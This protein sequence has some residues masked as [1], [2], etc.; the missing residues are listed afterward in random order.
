MSSQKA[1]FVPGHG[2]TEAIRSIRFVPK[3]DSMGR[4]ESTPASSTQNAA[5][6]EVWQG[7]RYGEATKELLTKFSTADRMATVYADGEMPLVRPSKSAVAFIHDAPGGFEIEFESEFI[8]PQNRVVRRTVVLDDY[9]TCHES[10]CEIKSAARLKSI[11]SRRNGPLRRTDS[12]ARPLGRF[13]GLTTSISQFFRVPPSETSLAARLDIPVEAG[14]VG[15]NRTTRLPSFTSQS[16]ND[17]G[18][19]PGA[20]GQPDL[21]VPRAGE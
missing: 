6:L 20:D 21:V 12:A 1:I 19:S 3:I 15:L 18:T 5:T 7:D 16:F 8:D 11:A 2:V 4:Q 9:G 17:L 10:L 13:W 14:D